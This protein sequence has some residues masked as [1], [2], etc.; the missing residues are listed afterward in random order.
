MSVLLNGHVKT[1]YQST[2]HSDY[3]KKEK[4][5]DRP[6][7]RMM[8][9]SHEQPTENDD[10]EILLKKIPRSPKQENVRRTLG[11]FPGVFCPVALS[12]FS[13]VLFLRGGMYKH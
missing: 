7:W 5:F 3:V 13:T 10:S 1:K 11:T 2:D 4:A 8:S 6:I 9:D 12:M